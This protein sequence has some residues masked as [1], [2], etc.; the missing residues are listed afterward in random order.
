M[1]PMTI[2]TPN[3]GGAVVTESGLIFIAAATD[4]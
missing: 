2:G 1:L 3:N 4:N